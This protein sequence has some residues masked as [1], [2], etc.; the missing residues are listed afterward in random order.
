M[1][2]PCLNFQQCSIL[3]SPKAKFSSLVDSEDAAAATTVPVLL[4]RHLAVQV[5]RQLSVCSS[6]GVLVA[7]IW[8]CCL[9]AQKTLEHRGSEVPV[10]TVSLTQRG[11]EEQRHRLT[12]IHTHRGFKETL[13]FIR[14][15]SARRGRAQ[16]TWSQVEDDADAKVSIKFKAQ[17][18]VL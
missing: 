10:N 16:C 2:P 9:H 14:S 15:S 4:I 6:F 18:L 12:L 5:E 11:E 13:P 8:I 1:L 7:G 3:S 17:P